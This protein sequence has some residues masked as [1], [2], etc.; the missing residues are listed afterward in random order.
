MIINFRHPQLTG[1][2]PVAAQRTPII[3]EIKFD[4][5]PEE[6]MAISILTISP[7]ISLRT[8]DATVVRFSRIHVITKRASFIRH[9]SVAGFGRGVN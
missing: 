6:V 1:S 5:K 2:F 8:K 4:L 7:E 9:L 3:E